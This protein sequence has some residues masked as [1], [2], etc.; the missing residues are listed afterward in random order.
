[1]HGSRKQYTNMDCCSVQWCELL[2]CGNVIL[3]KAKITPETLKVY[4]KG[5]SFGLDAGSLFHSILRWSVAVSTMRRQSSRIAAFLQADIQ[6]Q[7]S[8]GQGLPPLHEAR[9][10]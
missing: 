3:P 5:A 2:H 7:C 8:V 9:C 1:M 4:R 10:G 6:G